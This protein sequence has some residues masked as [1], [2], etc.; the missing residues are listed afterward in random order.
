M[1][2]KR[3]ERKIKKIQTT[4]ASTKTR[5]K[6]KVVAIILHHVSGYITFGLLVH[7]TENLYGHL[8][9]PPFFVAQSSLYPIVKTNYTPFKTDND[10]K[11]N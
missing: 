7:R 9:S 2:K 5:R 8:G 1:E 3:N 11:Q 4:T 10:A 6:R